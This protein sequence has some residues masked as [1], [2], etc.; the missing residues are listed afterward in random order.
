[1][2]FHVFLD[3]R[4]TNVRFRLVHGSFIVV[5]IYLCLQWSA[6]SIDKLPFSYTSDWDS[7]QDDTFCAVSAYLS[8]SF[9]VS[10]ETRSS[11]SEKYLLELLSIVWHEFFITCSWLVN[12]YVF[13]YIQHVFKYVVE[14][15][16]FYRS[17]AGEEGFVY[18]ET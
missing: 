12:V 8:H 2:K 3:L 14:S 11:L 17:W 13:V 6:F 16:F 15:N 18:L 5:F 1:M 4:I 7:S 9:V 10:S